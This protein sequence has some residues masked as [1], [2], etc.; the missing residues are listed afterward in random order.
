MTDVPDPA[1]GAAVPPA[2][3]DVAPPVPEGAGGGEPEG[4]LRPDLGGDAGAERRREQDEREEDERGYDDLRRVQQLVNNNFYGVVEASGAAFGFGAASAPGLAPGI[5]ES[6][7]TDRVLRFYVPPQPCFDEA[8]GT[9]RENAL[10]VLTG[11]DNCGRGAGS[12][13]L[14]RSILGEQAV[15]RSLSP[16]NALAE[17]AAS[18]D[19]RSGQGY[20]ILDYVGELRPDA[21]QT[22][23]I[24]RLSEELGRKGSYLVITA[25]DTVRR[26]LALRDHCVPWQV[27]DPEE[28]FDHCR[29]EL[30]HA[31][32]APDAERELLERVGE[33]RRPAV[34]VE[35]AVALSRGGVEAALDILRDRHRE[36]VQE[37]FRRRPAVDDLLALA[38]L[39]FLE[40]IPERTLERECA[41]L[42][43][44]VRNWEQS[45][46]TPAGEPDGSAG[47]PLGGRVAEQSR[48]RWRERAVGLVTTEFRLGPGR[49]AGRGERCLVFTSPR[50]RE[51]VIAELH[52]LYGY[53][54]WYP[55]RQWLGDLALRGD[56]DTR[57]EVA[58]GVALLARYALV[59]VDENLL[60]VWSDGVTSQR[61]TAALTLQFMCD[62]EHL[63]P[64]AL[65]T[66]VGWVD[67]R[68]AMRAVTAAMALTGRLGSLYRL[69]ALNWL[70]FLTNRG[71]RVAF[72]ARRS[73]V[74]L[75]QTAEADPERALLI[76]RYVRTVIAKSA[77]GS[78]ERAIA[79][80]AA[81][82]LLEATRLEESAEP[83]T[84]ALLR[85]VPDSVRHLGSLWA[86]VLHSS[87][88][89]R[90]VAALC[91]T[92][93][94]LRD[95]P[96][97][98]AAVRE[99]GE[100]MRKAMTAPQWAALG[101]HLSIALQHPDYA[102]PGT[103]RLAQVLIGSLRSRT[104]GESRRAIAPRT[105][106]DPL[107][108]AQGGRSK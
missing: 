69:Q 51:L 3:E 9:L 83:V 13:A 66:V 34:V 10:V 27:P 33:Q 16:A 61:V 95:D 70:W 74:L 108:S 59:E 101:R 5:I 39:A 15:V 76:L 86:D 68:G 44:H 73:L 75:L 52:D 35:A 41:A 14:L 29:A 42:A 31:G 36:Q 20:V 32:L 63:A 8:L 58:R 26:R 67:N 40:G 55:L 23:E 6:A 56:L 81:V 79:L 88:R 11:Q 30:P 78:R 64:Q 94:Q 92:L 47:A 106:T 54:L 38:A 99:L 18:R 53:D 50:I 105:S 77:P 17:L 12:L 45:G 25:G 87:N 98:T 60:T 103:H 19:L 97:V 107:S 22:Y 49:G 62:V 100:T 96:S 57:T 72:S 21:V 24:G 71:E 7:D 104:P 93:V 80:K 2:G 91:R 28:L 43:A 4:A 48:A 46:E 102:I 82:Q 65:S 37:W 1:G 84:A 89:S 85:T 90:A